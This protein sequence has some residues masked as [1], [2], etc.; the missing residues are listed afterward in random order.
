MSQSKSIES[1]LAVAKKSGH[2]IPVIFDN[3]ELTSLFD[4]DSSQIKK[5]IEY[6]QNDETLI[7]QIQEL[8]VTSSKEFLELSAE[9]QEEFDEE[10]SD[11]KMRG[12]H[13]LGED[14]SY[15]D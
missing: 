1:I 13:I 14:G 7:E 11:L 2:L 5:F 10:E 15:D 8:V 6:I 12:Y 4:I 9:D 3:D